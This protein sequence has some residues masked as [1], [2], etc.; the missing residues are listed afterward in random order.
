MTGI[1]DAY[2]LAGAGL[3]SQGDRLRVIAEN[4]ANADSTGLTPGSDPYRRKTITFKN[5]LDRE[6]GIEKVTVA[7]YGTDSTPFKLKYEPGHPA[8]NAQ[9]YVKFPNVDQVVEMV[10]MQEAQRAYEANVNVIDVT[11]SMISQTLGLLK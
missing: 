8:A 11:R 3:R 5:V 1:A 6:M 4:I 10:D 2:Y 9:G 7:S